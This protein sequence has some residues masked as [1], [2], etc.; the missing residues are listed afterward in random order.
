MH[1]IILAMSQI[2]PARHPLLYDVSQGARWIDEDQF[3]AWAEWA[4]EVE[5]WLHFLRERGALT[6]YLPRLRDRAARRDEALS[7]I[8]VAYFLETRCG[9]PII[10]WEPSGACGQ[11]GE[12]LV[13]LRSGGRMFVEVK[14][15]GWEAEVFAAQGPC[16]PRLRMPKYLDGEGGS[17]DPVTPVRKAVAKAYPKLPES[18]PTLLII[19]DDLKVALNSWPDTVEI[20]LYCERAEGYTAGYLAEDGCFVGQRYERLGAVGILNVE[21]KGASPE[22]RFTLFRNPGA[23]PSVALPPDVFEGE[24]QLITN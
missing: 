3:P 1:V 16:S 10:E 18:M 19:A 24:F 9:L 15:P 2:D 5:K 6:F 23:L 14:S 22:Y 21:L 8:K 12:F 4:D 7:E 13:G 20:A 17:T 11:K